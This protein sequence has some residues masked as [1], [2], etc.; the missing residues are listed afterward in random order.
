MA[1]AAPDN[2]IFGIDVECVATGVRS[3]DRTPARIVVVNCALETVFDEFVKPAEPV[4]SCIT[5]LTGVTATDLDDAQP[6]E[7]VLEKLS[8]VQPSFVALL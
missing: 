7:V 5:E 2:K 3:T 1:S 6:R 4:F 8:K